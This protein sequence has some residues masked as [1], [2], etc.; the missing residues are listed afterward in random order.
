VPFLYQRQDHIGFDYDAAVQILNNGTV[1]A[2]VEIPY[3]NLGGAIA[4][5]NFYVVE[6]GKLLTASP[7]ENVGP[8]TYIGP[9][10]VKSDVP[11]KVQGFIKTVS[12]EVYS[13]GPS[14]EEAS[15]IA[16][17]PFLYQRTDHIGFDYDS[18]VDVFNPG[19]I[20]TNVTIKLYNVAGTLVANNTY[21]LGPKS[22]T[23]PKVAEMLPGQTIFIGAAEIISEEPIV[24]QA[25][26][27][28]TS[29]LIYSI[30]PSLTT[31]TTTAYIPFLY[32][33]TDHIGF[34]Y[35]SGVNVL[36]PGTISTN[37]TIKLY[38]LAGTLVANNTYLVGPKAETIPK[39]AEM[40]PGQTIYIGPAEIISEQP[41]VAQAYIRTTTSKVYSVAPMV[42]KPESIID[43]HLPFLY[44]TVNNSHDASVQVMNPNAQQAAINISLYYKNGTIAGSYVRTLNAY[45]EVAP[46]VFEIVPNTVNFDGSAVI[47]ANQS[48]VA[49]GFIRKKS[50]NIYS[51]APPVER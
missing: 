15:T 35:D 25:Y 45:E 30:A 31:P 43:V 19:K 4:G 29:S 17:I 50:T 5:N 42:R 14:F 40:L 28:T 20:S 41:I 38:D 7:Y 24:A 6:P 22:E 8:I 48:I 37:V 23:I 2:S 27:R 11:V 46:K 51:V 49:Q 39:V 9:I 16:Y 10:V 44:S 18:G 36:N 34:D 13:M 32:Q 26:I 47:K 12:A 3:Y 1:N 33:R 21:L